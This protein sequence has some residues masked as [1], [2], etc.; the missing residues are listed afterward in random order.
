MVYE[1]DGEG[2]AREIERLGPGATA[3]PVVE[4]DAAALSRG[5]VRSFKRPHARSYLTTSIR[6]PT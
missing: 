6:L 5:R 3:S 2:A 4:W 1:N